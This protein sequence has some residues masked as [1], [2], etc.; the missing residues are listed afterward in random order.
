MD[1]P[2]DYYINQLIHF[3][4]IP[5]LTLLLS[6]FLRLPSG[7]HPSETLLP[8]RLPSR[9]RLPSRPRPSAASR[10][11]ERSRRALRQPRCGGAGRWAAGALG[12]RGGR[13][14][15]RQAGGLAG[16]WRRL[17][18]LVREGGSE[19]LSVCEG[20]KERAGEQAAGALRLQHEPGPAATRIPA[21][22]PGRAEPSWVGPGPCCSPCTVCGG[23]S[24]R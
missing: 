15:G 2:T 3:I 7:T 11:Q 4:F 18:S 14:A 20:G 23:T 8:S 16:G 12:G 24:P 1:S 9:L 6:P 17:C 19:S 22:K 10:R 13:Q 5:L 21:L